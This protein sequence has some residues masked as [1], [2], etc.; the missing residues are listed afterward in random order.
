MCAKRILVGVTVLLF[1]AVSALGKPGSS[2]A[3]PDLNG[4]LLADG[5]WLDSPLVA[6]NSPGMVVPAV[7]LASFNSNSECETP[8]PRPRS[9]EEAAIFQA[10]WR[11]VSTTRLTDHVDLLNGSAG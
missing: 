6:W 7:P 11:L 3:L 9:D 10:G 4:Q 2:D 5:A 1:V 8:A